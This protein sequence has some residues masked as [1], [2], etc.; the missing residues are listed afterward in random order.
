MKSS[1][2]YNNKIKENK[3]NRHLSP[4]EMRNTRILQMLSLESSFVAKLVLVVV[5]QALD[6]TAALRS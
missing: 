3:T 6:A 4:S 1:E 2:V 5:R